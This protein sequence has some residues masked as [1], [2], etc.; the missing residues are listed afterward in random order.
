MT[1][2]RVVEGVIVEKRNLSLSDVPEHKRS[3]WLDVV[4]EGS[5]PLFEDI[6]EA[7][8]VRTVRSEQPLATIKA[9]LLA[10]VDEDAG[11][12]RAKYLSTGAGMTMTYQEKHSQARA[13]DDI[14]EQAANA[15]TEAERDEQFPTLSASVG[16]EAETLWD[17]A[18]LVILKYEQFADLSRIIERT[19]LQGKKSI[20]DASDAAAARAAYEAIIWTV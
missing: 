3:L 2:A 1:I 8:R 5:G 20:S 13:V 12:V 15:L 18:Q 4:E 17:C 19:R 11:N 7:D 14:G 6:I 10:R 16:I 9:A